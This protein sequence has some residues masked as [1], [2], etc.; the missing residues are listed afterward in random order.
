MTRFVARIDLC[1]LCVADLDV[2]AANA[3][4]V[5]AR[6]RHGALAALTA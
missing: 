1:I 5:A 6:Q 2:P 4:C 3:D